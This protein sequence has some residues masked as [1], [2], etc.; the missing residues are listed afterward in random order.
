MKVQT[1]TVAGFV[2]SFVAGAIVGSFLFDTRIGF[3][4]SANLPFGQSNAYVTQRLAPV[5][6]RLRE[7]GCSCDAVIPTEN[8]CRTQLDDLLMKQLLEPTERD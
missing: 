5:C 8:T 3:G 7:Q 6:D 4:P 2:A 1:K